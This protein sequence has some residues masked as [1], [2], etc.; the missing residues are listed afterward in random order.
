M[1][2]TA[3]YISLILSLV[4]SLSCGKEHHSELSGEVSVASLWSLCT[5]RSREI[6][7]DIYISGY[8]VANDIYKELSKSLVIWDGSGGVELKVECDNLNDIAPLFSKVTLRCSGLSIGREGNKVVIGARP[9]SDFVVDRIAQNRLLNY[10]IVIDS[11]PAIPSGIDIHISDIDASMMLGYVAIHNLEVVDSEASE[12][13]CERDTTSYFDERYL[14]TIRHFT[15][16]CD[17]L[18]VVTSKE[19]RYASE[20]MPT[21]R[22]S[23]QGIIDWY[24]GDYALRLSSHQISPER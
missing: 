16:G 11:A 20:Q 12:A 3:L 23:M 10:L 7:E 4:V 5:E 1:P 13:W 17:T 21:S 8:V 2:K 6:K 9:T 22:C 19:C 18:R 24:D 14:T 15:D